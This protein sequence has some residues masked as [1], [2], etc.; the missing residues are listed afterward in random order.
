MANFQDSMKVKSVSQI[1]SAAVLPQRKPRFP[2]IGS[3]LPLTLHGEAVPWAK[4][5]RMKPAGKGCSL[6]SHVQLLLKT[7]KK[8]K[9]KNR[10]KSPAVLS[11]ALIR[12][13]VQSKARQFCSCWAAL[14]KGAAVLGRLLQPNGFTEPDVA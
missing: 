6:C 10:N 11:W 14:W 4:A 3:V 1:K 7:E 2:F 9:W 5:S 12:P 8:K 13:W